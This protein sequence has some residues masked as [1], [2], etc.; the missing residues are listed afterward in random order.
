VVSA[1]QPSVAVLRDL[2]LNPL[3]AEVYAFLLAHEPMTA[4]AIGR[5]IGKATAN[6]YKAVESLSRLGAVMV[7]E[8]ERRVC[9][10]IPVREFL[11]HARA[12]FLAKAHAAADVL[13]GL[14]RDSYDERIYRIENVAEALER[15]AA[16]LGRARRVAV[17]DAFPRSL[18]RMV[19]AIKKAARRGVEVLVEAYRPI[20]IQGASVVVAQTG[21]SSV[22][23]W[24]AEQLNAVVDGREV[25][26][27][28][29][30]LDLSEVHQ[31]LWSRSL[32]LAC[33]IHS[34]LRSEHTIH[35]MHEA[36]RNGQRRSDL[37]RVLAGHRFFVSGRVPGQEELHARFVKR[38]PNDRQSRNERGAR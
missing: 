36:L 1:S 25:L 37:R 26:L 15:C 5:A 9:R 17:V 29:M 38:T 11:G 20:E 14:E 24:G 22:D 28:L 3:E 13:G 4:Y 16:M 23:L 6:V 2:G 30:S 33:L 10:A 32:Y 34:G 8:G 7:E 21:Q 19:P 31:G 18:E 35:R 27:A 12:A